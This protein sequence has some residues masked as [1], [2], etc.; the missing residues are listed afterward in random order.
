M[1]P[2]LQ[3]P[4][5]GR[6]RTR[7]SPQERR[8]QLLA[9]GVE[10]LADRPLESI[11]VE[12]LAAAAGVSPGLVFYYFG[13]RQGLHQEIVRTA[14]DAMLH[15]TE[16]RPELPPLERLDDVLERFVAFVQEHDATFYS[17][18]R[19][20]SSGDPQVRSTVQHARDV[21]TG[22]TTEI[23]DELGIERTPLLDVAIRAWISLAEQAL[24][25]AATD[26]AVPTHELVGFL[27]RS[28]L[29]TIQAAHP[30]AAQP[31]HR[32]AAP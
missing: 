11:S 12:D 10:W 7:L 20:A 27:S 32:P 8:Q 2:A 23:L 24:V 30:Q 9:Q 16:P 3:G 14:R 29:A 28:A 6:R 5:G 21:L 25:D 1:P 15:A 31:P 13:S 26:E 22:H 18:V 4:T 19:G 17:I